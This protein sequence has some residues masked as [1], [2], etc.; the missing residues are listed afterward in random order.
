LLA[1]AGPGLFLDERKQNK[2]TTNARYDIAGPIPSDNLLHVLPLAA[3]G[4][5]VVDIQF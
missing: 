4:Y 1:T 2:N 5:E 3:A